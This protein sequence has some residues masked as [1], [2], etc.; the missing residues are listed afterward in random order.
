MKEMQSLVHTEAQYPDSQ[1]AKTMHARTH[2]HMR[3]LRSR[4][5]PHTLPDNGGYTCLS[6]CRLQHVKTWIYIVRSTASVYMHK[7]L[8]GLSLQ[9]LLPWSREDSTLETTSI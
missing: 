4:T 6:A 2:K 7:K 9:N 5:F 1:T 8:S 3:T